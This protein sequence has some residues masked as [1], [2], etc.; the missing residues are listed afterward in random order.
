MIA[1]IPAQ[2][3]ENYLIRANKRFSPILKSKKAPAYLTVTLILISLSF[4]G[5]FAIRPTLVTAVTLIKTVS[6]LRKL[7]ADYESKISSIIRAQSEYEKIRDNLPL[8]DL[9][10]PG[11]TDFHILA[12][13]ME[14]NAHQS[15]LIINQLQIDGGPISKPQSGSVMKKYGFS[16]VATGDYSSVF[17]FISHLFN[18]KRIITVNSL[19]VSP[20]TSSSSASLRFTIKGTA[21]YEP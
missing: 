19:D 2:P 15:N 8:L 11:N 13:S 7:N 10:L 6:D 17:S 21:F 3:K 5:I 1:K 20:E 14:N 18:A 9:A 12:K 16:I 4:F